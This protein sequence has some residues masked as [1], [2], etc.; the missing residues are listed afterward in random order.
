[1]RQIAERIKKRFGIFLCK[2][3]LLFNPQIVLK[4]IFK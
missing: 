3:L 1:M 2:T 4:T